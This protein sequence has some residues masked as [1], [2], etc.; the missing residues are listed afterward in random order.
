MSHA[1]TMAAVCNIV[2]RPSDPGGP[3]QGAH[4]RVL[5]WFYLYMSENSDRMK[6]ME[7][8]GH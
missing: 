8:F 1:A 4:F 5:A 3:G 7:L 6:T 2:E